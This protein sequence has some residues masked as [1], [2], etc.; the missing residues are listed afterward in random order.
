M[1][2]F[3]RAGVVFA[4]GPEVAVIAEIDFLAG[5]LLE[6]RLHGEVF[7]SEIGGEMSVAGDWIDRGGESRPDMLDIGK[8][9]VHLREGEFPGVDHRLCN[10]FRRG[11]GLRLRF[12]S[13]QNTVRGVR[14]NRVDF[15]AAEVDSESKVI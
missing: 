10:F 1:A 8:S 3:R 12:G 4:Q 14:D 7:Q 9:Q 13:C 2:A 5:Q 15:T 11:I 6:N